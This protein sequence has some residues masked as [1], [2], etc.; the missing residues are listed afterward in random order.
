MDREKHAKA[1][2]L[3]KGIIKLKNRL[4][5]ITEIK[6]ASDHIYFGEWGNMK[7][8]VGP[9]M[10]KTFLMLAQQE[11]EEELEDLEKEYKA[12]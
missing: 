4:N 6:G 5:L 3:K 10:K 7:V 12:L 9:K 2:E 8:E 1:D 11:A